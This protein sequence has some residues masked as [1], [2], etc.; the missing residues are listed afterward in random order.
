M[1]W[2]NQQIELDPDNIDIEKTKEMENFKSCIRFVTWV[3]PF[4]SQKL[5]FILIVLLPVPIKAEHSSDEP[6]RKSFKEN[7]WEQEDDGTDT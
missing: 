4:S 1:Q 7:S 6:N 5:T 3:T 2:N